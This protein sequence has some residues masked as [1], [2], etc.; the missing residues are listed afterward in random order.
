MAGAVAKTKKADVVEFDPSMF[1]ADASSR[2][3]CSVVK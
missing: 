2:Q 1:E 3:V